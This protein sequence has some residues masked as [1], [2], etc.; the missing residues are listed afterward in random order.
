M[1]KFEK[2]NG[3]YFTINM[4][5]G[6]RKQYVFMIFANRELYYQKKVLEF[7]SQNGL[8]YNEILPGPPFSNSFIA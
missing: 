1:G 5:T 7:L 2:H 3:R 4:L 6:I 8:V